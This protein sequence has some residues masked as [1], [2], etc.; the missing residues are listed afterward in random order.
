MTEAYRFDVHGRPMAVVRGAVGWQAFRLGNE[1]KRRPAD[2]YVPAT[3]A[4]AELRT[5]LADL[6]HEGATPRHPDVLARD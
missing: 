4:P 3:L 1:G 5:W 2:A 6:F